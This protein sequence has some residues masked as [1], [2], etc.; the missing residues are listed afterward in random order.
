MKK[1]FII[2]ILLSIV[3]CAIAPYAVLAQ[4]QPKNFKF[5]SKITGDVA[6]KPVV[7]ASTAQVIDEMKKLYNEI[8]AIRYTDPNGQE[9]IIYMEIMDGATIANLTILEFIPKT[10]T[11]CAISHG[12]NVQFS[13]EFWDNFVA[14][15]GKNL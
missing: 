3:G 5:N 6:P 9:V 11:G 8:P 1:L 10:D 14:K 12:N 2:I 7:C 4:E 13:K 15:I